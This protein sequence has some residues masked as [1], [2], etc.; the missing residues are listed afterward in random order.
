MKQRHQFCPV[1]NRKPPQTFK[2]PHHPEDGVVRHL[3]HM[4]Y[5]GVKVLIPIPATCHSGQSITAHFLQ[6]SPYLR[7][8]GTPPI[9]KCRWIFIFRPGQERFHVV[10]IDHYAVLRLKNG[11]KEFLEPLR[12]RSIRNAIYRTDDLRPLRIKEISPELGELIRKLPRLIILV[13]YLIAPYR[14]A[15]LFLTRKHGQRPKS[16][17]TFPQSAQAL[18]HE[19][20]LSRPVFPAKLVQFPPPADEP[21]GQYPPLIRPF[22]RPLQLRL[23]ILREFL[24]QLLTQRII[25]PSVI[26]H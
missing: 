24:R 22:E 2:P 1:H 10:Q 4:D 20:V 7:H 17:R 5:V 11:L 19:Y 26:E 6:Y 13:L 8:F 3:R 21:G 16:Q 15:K 12:F 23:L 14:Q 25:R 18:K 9:P